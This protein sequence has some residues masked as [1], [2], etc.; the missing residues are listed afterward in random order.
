MFSDMNGPAEELGLRASFWH[1]RRGFSLSPFDRL[2]F[3]RVMA[4]Y[5]RT[6][7]GELRYALSAR[8]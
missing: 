6:S 1:K 8:R 3:S 7:R 4:Y 5:A 2:P